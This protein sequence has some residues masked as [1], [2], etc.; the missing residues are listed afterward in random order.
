LRE[1]YKTACK[2]IIEVMKDRVMVI[3]ST[4]ANETRLFRVKPRNPARIIRFSSVIS[5]MCIISCITFRLLF[6]VCDV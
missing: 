3:T 6:L 4:A 5:I 2:R 1:K